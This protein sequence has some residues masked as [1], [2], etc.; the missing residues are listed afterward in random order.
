MPRLLSTACL[1]LAA[2]AVPSCRQATGLDQFLVQCVPGEAGCPDSGAPEDCESGLDSNGDGVLPA[3]CTGDVAWARVT[4]GT[5]N[6]NCSDGLNGYQI[7]ATRRLGGL[8]SFGR[9]AGSAGALSGSLVGCQTCSGEGTALDSEGENIRFGPALHCDDDTLSA[10]LARGQAHGYAASAVDIS[11]LRSI[12]V[13]A[14]RLDDASYAFRW[15]WQPP[16]A[17]PWLLIAADTSALVAIG[18]SGRILF[19]EPDEDFPAAR[20][21]QLANATPSSIALT[22]AAGARTLLLAGQTVSPGSDPGPCDLGATSP[23]AFVAKVP[24][25]QGSPDPAA[26]AQLAC[27]GFPLELDI[28]TDTKS[29]SMRVAALPDGRACWAYLG[30]NGAASPEVRRLRVGCFGLEPGAASWKQEGELGGEVPVGVD[31]AIDPFGHAVVAAPVSRATQL[32]LW[33]GVSVPLGAADT[34]NILVAKLHRDTGA[35]IW[36]R[37]LAAPGASVVQDVHVTVDDDG[38]VRLAFVANSTA[39]AGG[40]FLGLPSSS[41]LAVHFVGLLP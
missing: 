8:Q 2:L 14:H 32:S 16:D 22:R 1:L 38:L 23:T 6:L 37:L 10:G 18:Q 19:A 11:S 3:E 15:E 39:L 40:G 13:S 7:A 9:W 34:T 21:H 41:G 12:M 35:V 4:Q 27:A 20:F 24:L 28:G 31:V 36:A 26:A 33:G 29:P 5:S 30:T 17:V 25:G